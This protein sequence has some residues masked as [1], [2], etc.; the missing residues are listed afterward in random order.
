[1]SKEKPE[2]ADRPPGQIHP[3]ESSEKRLRDANEQLTLATLRAQEQADESAVRYRDL[4]EGLDAVV[5]EADPDPWRYTFVSHQA[6]GMFGH[7]A[8][9]WLQEP[10]FWIELIHPKDRQR[11]VNACKAGV[12]QAG[13]RIEYR[14]HALDGRVFW[15]ALVA[16]VRKQDD[17]PTRVRGLLL[18]ITESKAQAERLRQVIRDLEASQASLKEKVEELEKFQD[19][20]IGRELKMIQLEKELAHLQRELAKLQSDRRENP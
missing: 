8:E 1:M 19:L 9:R 12:T 17:R 18:D 20:T 3:P 13:F 4:V 15:V 2:A 11:T 10:N 14:A 16:Q 5:W 7:P 6:Q